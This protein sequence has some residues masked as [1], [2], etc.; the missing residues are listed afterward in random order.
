MFQKIIYLLLISLFSINIFAY[1][2]PEIN[3]LKKLKPTI[4]LFTAES[5]VVN[6]IEKYKLIWKTENSTHVQIT[7]LGNVK[8]S[9][10]IIITKKEYQRGPI[11]LTVTSVENSFS[12]SK[13]INKFSK[14]EKE[15]PIILKK[16]SK[17]ISQEFY[18]PIPYG[19]RV[20]PRRYRRY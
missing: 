10:S 20:G 11:T 4:I 8:L 1:E 14:A 5:I 13:T 19:R 16:E 18:R 6:N 2:L 3:F 12:D 7:F 17:G 9:D 15:A